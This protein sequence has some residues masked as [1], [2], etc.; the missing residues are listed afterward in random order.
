[1]VA[2]FSAAGFLVHTP[3]GPRKSGMPDSVEIPAPVS[4]TTARASRSQAAMRS[5]ASS[6]PVDTAGGYRPTGD[7]RGGGGTR[8]AIPGRRSPGDDGPP[9][10]GTATGRRPGAGM[11]AVAGAG[12]PP[13]GAPLVAA[14]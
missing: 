4:T 7:R 13:I 1:M 3:S 6:V 2:V 12:R 9:S 5:V 14:G 8:G 11:S 10:P